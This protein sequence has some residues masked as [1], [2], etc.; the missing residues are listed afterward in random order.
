ML[1]D[2]NIVFN[3]YKE[4]IVGKIWY[5][6][7]T[8]NKMSQSLRKKKSLESHPHTTPMLKPEPLS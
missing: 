3:F 5:Y 7:M 2:I 6:G 1:F 4:Y 8:C